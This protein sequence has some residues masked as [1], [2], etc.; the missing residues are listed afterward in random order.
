[1]YTVEP[2][3]EGHFGTL[4]L[5]LILIHYSSTPGHRMVS[6]LYIEVSTFQRFVI[7]R[8][9]CICIIHMYVL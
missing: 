9:H 1:M 7:E 6:L 5:V 4:L 2:I 3:Y 8:F